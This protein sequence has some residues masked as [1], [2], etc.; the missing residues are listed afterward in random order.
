MKAKL[1]LSPIGI[2]LI[3]EPSDI[4]S[5]TE[6]DLFLILPDKHC[7]P[8]SDRIATYSGKTN[9]VLDIDTVRLGKYLKNYL[10]DCKKLAQTLRI[11]G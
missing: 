11:A 2:K 3:L 10:S 4:A 1:N 9:L 7:R 8:L 5:V 6:Q